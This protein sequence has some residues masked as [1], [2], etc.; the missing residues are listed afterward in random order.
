MFVNQVKITLLVCTDT[1]PAGTS[2]YCM[3]LLPTLRSISVGQCF[4]H[5]GGD[6]EIVVRD[7]VL[8][9]PLVVTR[10]PRQHAVKRVEQ[11]VHRPSYDYVVV[12]ANNCRY[13]DHAV[14]DSCNRYDTCSR[15][16]THVKS[17]TNHSN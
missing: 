15:V 1:P 8:G 12:D 17:F 11:V 10:T 16:A 13:D 7:A 4:V 5:I 3:C 6:M 14:T 9:V 2:R